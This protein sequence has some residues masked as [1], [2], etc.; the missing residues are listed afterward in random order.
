[1]ISD[2]TWRMAQVAKLYYL[3]NLTQ[4]TIAKRLNISRS[5]ISR[6]LDVAKT[7]GIIEVKIN[8]FWQR[9]ENLENALCD[10]YGLQAARILKC[11]EDQSYDEILEGLG[12]LAAQY[13]QEIVRPDTVVAITS[14]KSLFH[15]INALETQ[16]KN[17]TIVQV[18]GLANCEN[19]LIDGPELAQLMVRRLGGHYTYMQAPFIVKDPE[20]HRKIYKERPFQNIISLIQRA[21]YAIVGVGSINP[22]NSS[23]LRTGFSVDSLEELIRCGAVGE[24]SGQIFNHRGQPVH[25]DKAQKAV[26]IDL[27]YLK[28]IP[29]VIGVAGGKI[30]TEAIRGA[31]N[32]KILDVAVTDQYTAETLLKL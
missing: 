30:K 18:M 31:L 6:M 25:S 4:S 16:N 27:K 8:Y 29:C 11:V 13:F 15:T 24:I 5:T 19:P 1:M 20:L 22:S 9:V 17:L 12:F 3:D 14:G 26:S 7:N 2:K 23:L 28:E 10:K 32:G 21:S